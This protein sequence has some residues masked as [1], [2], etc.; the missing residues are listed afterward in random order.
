[1]KKSELYDIVYIDHVLDYIVI[2]EKI[3]LCGNRDFITELAI[4]RAMEVIG[5][6]AN[7]VSKELKIRHSDVP[8]RQIVDMRNMLIHGYFEVDMKEVWSACE[9]DIPLLKEQIIK[10]K[11]ELKDAN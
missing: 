1:M 10:I 5:E 2:V 9:K 6:A 4:V 7:N 11:E 3:L 8:W